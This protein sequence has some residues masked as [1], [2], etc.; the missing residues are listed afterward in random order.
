MILVK[1]KKMNE[2]DFAKI[3]KELTAVAEM[4]RTNQDEKQS[5]LDDFDKERTRY[6]LGKISK[7][8][9]S[10][11][12]RKVNKELSRL[13]NAI[14]KGMGNVNTLSTRISNFSERQK[15]NRFTV[16]LEGIKLVS[17]GKKKKKKP[18][19]KKKPKKKAK[20][21]PKPKKKKTSKKRKR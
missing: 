18:A 8:A 21:R 17:G 14:K 12:V 4:I 19:K 13:D 11:S 2:T 9:F 10:S 6:R 5:V 1:T 20:K 16:S 7:K 15:P 3:V